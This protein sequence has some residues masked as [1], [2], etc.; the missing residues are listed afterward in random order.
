MVTINITFIFSYVNSGYLKYHPL[1][2]ILHS[3][4]KAEYLKAG[5][6]QRCEPPTPKVDSLL[7]I[8]MLL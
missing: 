5:G 2:L 3:P 6:R 8:L 4:N 1:I 7:L